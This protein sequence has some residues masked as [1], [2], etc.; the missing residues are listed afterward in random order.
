MVGRGGGY[1][2]QGGGRTQVKEITIPS[3][4]GG[5]I[6]G[7]HGSRISEIRSVCALQHTV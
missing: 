1:D 7:R 4:L 6:I 2:M 5:S 3:E